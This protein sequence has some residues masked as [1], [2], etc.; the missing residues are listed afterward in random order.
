MSVH[1][2][3]SPTF[4][5]VDF[6]VK[7]LTLFLLYLPFLFSK[8]YL[9]GSSDSIPDDLLKFILN[10]F[11]ISDLEDFISFLLKAFSVRILEDFRLLFDVRCC[12]LSDGSIGF[13]SC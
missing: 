6:L 3:N 4:L 2:S 12:F 7:V 11:S 8:S 1:D 5:R 9:T 10:E 13:L